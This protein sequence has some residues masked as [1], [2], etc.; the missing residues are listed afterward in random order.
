MNP[1]RA[2]NPVGPSRPGLL[3]GRV[4]VIAGV[5]VGLGRDVALAFAREGADVV[6]AARRRDVTDQVADEVA[7]LGRRA[8]VVEMDLRDPEDCAALA[9]T[10]VAELGRIDSLVTVA[11]LTSDRSRLVDTSPDL[12]NWRPQF[13]TNLFGT[14]QIVRAVVPQMIEQGSGR[15]I[16]VN[17]MAIRLVAPRMASYIGSKAALESIARVLALELGPH[18][19]RVNSIHPGYMGGD[20]VDQIFHRRA[21]DH[22][23]TFEQEYEQVRSGLALGYIPPTPEYAGTIVYLAS[24]LSL[25][26]TGESI[27]VN[28]GQTRH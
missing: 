2:T 11:Y 26:V 21:A 19:I 25:P 24:D 22:G 23:T 16:F 18:G 27:W 14:L 6:L 20:R 15:I 7:E 9:E 3:E 13:D 28:A 5:G 4:G 12:A 1:D 10:T 8:V 17:T